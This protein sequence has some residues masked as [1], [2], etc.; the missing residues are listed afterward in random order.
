[1]PIEAAAG[2]VSRRQLYIILGAIVL[3]ALGLRIA[4]AQGALWLDEAWSA[5]FAHEARTPAGVFFTI[6]HDNNH[7]L[8]S[9]WMQLTGWGAPPLLTRGLSIITSTLTVIVAGLIAARRGMLCAALT[10]ALFAISPIMVNYGS[11][12]RGYAPMV[13]AL[14]SA[15]WIVDRWLQDPGRPPPARSLAIVVALGMLAHLT[16]LFGLV[17]LAAWTLLS[18][19]RTL[20]PK[21]A[22][23][24]SGPLL[25]RAMLAAFAILALVTVAALA[26]PAGHLEVGSYEPFTLRQWLEGVSQ[27]FAYTIGI[28]ADA[29]PSIKIGLAIVLTLA[30]MYLLPSRDRLPF[31][32]VAI[33]GLPLAIAL[34]HI[35][36]SGFARYY[37]VSSVAFLLLLGEALAFVL[38]QQR[39][40][41]RIAGASILVAMLVGSGMLDARLMANRRA[42]P[43][44]AMQ[45]IIRRSPEG[46][47]ILRG[48][49]R[50]EAVINAAAASL[51]YQAHIVA[52]PCP[53]PPF[54]F[55]EEGGI[56]SSPPARNICGLSYQR[57]ASAQPVGLSGMSWALYQR[58]E[59]HPM[60][61]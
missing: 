19:L 30:A 59:P 5:V 9:L 12:A 46:A 10:A 20:P 38:R 39:L 50:D 14:V 8:N 60:P 51:H 26:S 34:L 24:R 1:M 48:Q 58:P 52:D 29:S 27:M 49:L 28:P 54:L 16:M 7:H 21:E 31:Y 56:A 40:P 3:V 4:S 13:L 32:M 36:N 61:E 35:G 57:I 44:L 2:S 6:N 11:E 33:F 53:P 25:L 23:Q 43:G 42:D 18:L 22:L 41:P 15:I 37:L 45:E 55:V 17:A 47:T